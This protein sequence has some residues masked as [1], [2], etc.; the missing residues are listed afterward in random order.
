[1]SKRTKA[2]L[3][4]LEEDEVEDVTPQEPQEM[5]QDFHDTNFIPFP[6]RRQRAHTHMDEQFGKFVE[7]IQKL[8]INIPL[9]DAIQ[10]PTYVKYI[11][12]IMNKERPLPTTEVIKLTGECSEAILN[13]SPTKKKD[14]GF[15]T[16]DCSIGSQHFD[17]ALCDLGASDSMIPKSVFDKLTY[18]IIEPAS[19]CL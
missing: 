19:M 12:D 6:R 9:L 13:T 11:R 8:Y 2:V 7:V 5:R 18:S 14:P 1:M 17:N 10:V 4:I 3:V 15:P 16:I